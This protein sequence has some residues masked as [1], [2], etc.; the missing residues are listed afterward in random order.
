MAKRI[1]EEKLAEQI[2]TALENVWFNPH[3]VASILVNNYSLYHQDKLVELMA[4]VIK[5][6]SERFT[7]EWVE[8]EVTSEGLLLSSHLAEIVKA[9]NK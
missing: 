5:K 1:P 2:G 7:H 6:Q 4:E 3:I 8:H 9:H